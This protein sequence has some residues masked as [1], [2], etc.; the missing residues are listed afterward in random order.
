[1]WALLRALAPLIR[2]GYVR[3]WVI[4]PK[5]G[6]EFGIGEE[7]Y[8]EFAESDQ[9]G[10]KLITKYTSILDAR[11]LELGRQGVRTFTPSLETPLELL[12]CD[13]L[14]AMTAYADKAIRAPFEL[15]LSKALTQ[16]R[17]VGGR[18]VAASQEPTK[19]VIPMRGLFPTKIALRLDSASYVDMCLGE[20]MRDA[21]A[22][23]DKIPEYLAGVAY[24]KKDGRREPLR[25]RA[26]YTTDDDIT[27]LVKYCTDRG[28]TVT[29][30]RREATDDEHAGQAE[31]DIY[32]FDFESIEDA[33]DEI[34]EI[35][36]FEDDEGDEEIA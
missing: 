26:A 1:M 3:L 20:G 16:Y 14:A 35:G 36:Y 27:E 17:A 23:A 5:G 6:M 10:Q 31:K 19:D 15:D 22:F 25:V 8:Y 30:I 21:G 12:I 28:A 11:K 18:T 24:V 29:P 13:E 34:E 4:D 33:D 9:A 7:M 2:A 32:S